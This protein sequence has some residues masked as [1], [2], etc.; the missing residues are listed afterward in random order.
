MNE[1]GFRGTLASEG[2]SAMK[3]YQNGT[4]FVMLEKQW[5]S[6]IILNERTEGE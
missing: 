3:L 1:W 6:A 2:Y 5:Q 4:Y